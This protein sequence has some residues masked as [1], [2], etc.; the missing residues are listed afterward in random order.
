MNMTCFRH[1]LLYDPNN[2]YTLQNDI[3]CSNFFYFVI[4]S[5]VFMFFLLYIIKNTIKADPSFARDP[6]ACPCACTQR[7]APCAVRQGHGPR[8]DTCTWI[9]PSK[10]FM[11][12]FFASTH[13]D[14]AHGNAH[15]HVQIDGQR[16][17]LAGLVLLC[18]VVLFPFISF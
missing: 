14:H 8:T 7:I 13:T 10:F 6:Y 16:P 15:D 1:I 11:C 3:L 4:H 18:M 5:N 2:K 9:A 17:V 12:T